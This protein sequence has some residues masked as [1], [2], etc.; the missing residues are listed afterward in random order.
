MATDMFSMWLK[1]I[2]IIPRLS[3]EEWNRLDIISRWLIATRAAVLIM[4]FISAAIAG[5]WGIRNH[6]FD[7]LTWLLVALGLVLAHATN[8]LVNDITDFQKGVDKD[9]YYRTQYGPQP[10]AHGFMTL[11]ESWT[12]AAVTG[13]LA[14]LIGFYLVYARGGLTLAF[15]LAGAFFVLLYTY[16]LKYIGLGELAVLLV[17]GPLMMGGGYYV[18]S[19][20]WDWNLVWAGLPYAL[21]TTGVIFGKHIDKLEDDRQK[22]IHTLPVIIGERNARYLL[23]AITSLQYL[24]V[25]WLVLAGIFT[26]LMLIV[27]FAFPMFLRFF[28]AYLQPRPA[29]PPPLPQQPKS[30]WAAFWEGDDYP[31]EGWPMWFVAFAFIHNRRFGILFLLGF[32]TDALLR[33]QGIL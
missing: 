25:V 26:P 23:A 29:A 22:G 30:K 12:Y 17:W 19:G 7:W 14:A 31:P 28:K 10:L 4:T 3:K 6:H 33:S 18:L 15:M 11:R 20:S 13:L 27:F 8:N 16:P 2:Q 5:L 21:G 1:A 9:N 24:L 32:I